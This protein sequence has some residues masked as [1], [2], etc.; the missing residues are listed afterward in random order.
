MQTPLFY[1]ASFSTAGRPDL[2][3]ALRFFYESAE[4]V[5]EVTC[6]IAYQPVVELMLRV[7]GGE[8]VRDTATSIVYLTQ[9]GDTDLRRVIG[10]Y[11]GLMRQIAGKLTPVSF[12]YATTKD[13]QYD[14]RYEEK[15]G[16]QPFEIGVGL[17]CPPN[18]P[19]PWCRAAKETELV[20][21][22]TSTQKG[23]EFVLALTQ[24]AHRVEK[25]FATY[26]ALAAIFQSL[27]RGRS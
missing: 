23:G 10:V 17:S 3:I 16:H 20:A 27:L 1:Q 4:L 12:T 14:I 18:V 25:R 22:I 6:P 9:H 19:T 24:A 13:S 15:S 26:E 2:D 21:D 5:C 8:R 11:Q 7:N